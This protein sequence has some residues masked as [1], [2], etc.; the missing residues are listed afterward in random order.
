MNFEECPT[1]KIMTHFSGL[2]CN[3]HCGFLCEC[4]YRCVCLH[5][6]CTTED[7]PAA[8][9]L[10]DCMHLNVNDGETHKHT[11]APRQCLTDWLL[12][13]SARSPRPCLVTMGRYHTGACLTP[14][15]N[16]AFF[17]WWHHKKLCRDICDYWSLFSGELSMT[18]FP[19]PV[20]ESAPTLHILK[21]VSLKHIWINS[22]AH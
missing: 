5:W 12:L 22:L 11:Q 18:L 21:L 19:K 17:L 9:M 15:V 7:H 10:E 13:L 6:L 8:R 3:E 20:S 14:T 1:L 2:V 16:K 4:V